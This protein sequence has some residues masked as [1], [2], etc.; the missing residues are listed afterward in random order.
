MRSN[1]T[2][3]LLGGLLLLVA[4]VLFAAFFDPW[5]LVD[6]L[7]AFSLA[8]FARHIF[9]KDGLAWKVAAVLLVPALLWLYFLPKDLK[10]RLRALREKEQRMPLSH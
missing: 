9:E 2:K 8:T 7:V 4:I 6:A 1:N 5:R 10:R 3:T